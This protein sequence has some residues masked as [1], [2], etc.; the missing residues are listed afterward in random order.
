M[1]ENKIKGAVNKALEQLLDS[2]QYLLSN[3]V[4]ERSISHRLAIYLE[5]LF[6]EWHVDCEYNKNHDDPKRLRIPRR[7]IVSADTQATTVYPDI[8]VHKRNTDKNLL[9]IEMKKTSNQEDDIYDLHKLKAFKEQLG[10][11]YSI[12]LKLKVGATVSQRLFWG[13]RESNWFIETM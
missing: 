7:K 13:E 8:I 4:N 9:V 5:P 11:E 3:D 10:Y 2:D 6:P 12:F 1:D